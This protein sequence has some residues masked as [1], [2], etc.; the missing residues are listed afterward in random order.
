MIPKGGY[1]FSAKI[2]LK[3][4]VERDDDSTRSHRALGWLFDR[5]PEPDRGDGL[6]ALPDRQR[7]VLGVPAEERVL[8]H[9][10]GGAQ[11]FPL[12]DGAARELD[13]DGVSLR[14]ALECG[15]KVEAWHGR[16]MRKPRQWLH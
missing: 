2:M 1:R 5:Q 7:D 9:L 12:G 3:Q 4:R 16:P 6:F 14:L 8:P 10:G 15:V 13:P 11:G